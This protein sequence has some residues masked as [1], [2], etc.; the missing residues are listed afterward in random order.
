MTAM[1]ISF[2]FFVYSTF[3]VFIRLYAGQD[4]TYSHTLTNT[5]E[6]ALTTSLAYTHTKRPG[7]SSFQLKT[8]IFILTQNRVEI[9]FHPEKK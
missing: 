5:P 4:N 7:S 9:I 3:F 1:I 8:K 6:Y 2:V